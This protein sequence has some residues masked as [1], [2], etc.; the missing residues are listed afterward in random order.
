M[1]DILNIFRRVYN[2][3]YTPL[4]KRRF[5]HCGTNVHF[6][7][8]DSHFSYESIHI[9][10]HVS[11]GYGADM[12]ATRSKII[13]GNHVVFA[14]KVSIRGGDHRTDLVGAYID[15]VNDSMKLPENDKDVIF[16]GDNWIGM[17]VIILKGVT[18]GKGSIIAAGAVVN[19]SVPPYS[20]V[21][22]VPAKVIKFRFTPSQIIEHEKLLDPEL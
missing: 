9:G 21:G 10:N 19:K 16:E 3:I 18:V 5:L 6:S 11:I 4:Y 15:T 2:K 7:P 14:P 17:N 13:I 20:V 1:I 8:I 22:G 12:I